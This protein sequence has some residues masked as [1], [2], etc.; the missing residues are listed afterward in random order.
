MVPG[1]S[2]EKNRGILESSCQVLVRSLADFQVEAVHSCK[3]ISA[4]NFVGPAFPDLHD[5]A[6]ER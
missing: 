2:P 4:H 6:A 5:P 1:S 3:E